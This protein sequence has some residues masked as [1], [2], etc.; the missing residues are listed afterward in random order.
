MNISDSD[1][2]RALKSESWYYLEGMVL[3]DLPASA[4]RDLDFGD[5]DNSVFLMPSVDWSVESERLEAELGRIIIRLLFA[6]QKFHQPRLI[7]HKI[8]TTS[9]NDSNLRELETL[10]ECYHFDMVGIRYGQT[11]AII[12]SAFPS[13]QHNDRSKVRLYGIKDIRKI[14][15]EYDSSTLRDWFLTVNTITDEKSK[16]RAR[17]IIRHIRNVYYKREKESCPVSEDFL[18]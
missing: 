4:F 5:I 11:K 12:D 7:L 8:D 15:S 13:V 17:E 6:S 18:E 14:F 10:F 16:N 2:I 9:L 3:D 1:V